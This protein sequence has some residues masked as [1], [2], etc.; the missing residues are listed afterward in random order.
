MDRVHISSFNEVIVLCEDNCLQ[1]RK[2]QILFVLQKDSPADGKHLLS[3]DGIKGVLRVV[4]LRREKGV[5]G[6]SQIK[7]TKTVTPAKFRLN[8]EITKRQGGI[9]C[10]AIDE[11][12]KSSKAIDERVIIN[13]RDKNVVIA[14]FRNKNVYQ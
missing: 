10:G 9:T 6:K 2:H 12:R 7:M 14:R 8:T 4:N 1:W 3:K 5:R 11:P 13:F